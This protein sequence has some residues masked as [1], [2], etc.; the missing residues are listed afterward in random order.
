MT[1]M[2]ARSPSRR[3]LAAGA[4]A[5]LSFAAAGPAR[6]DVA[7]QIIGLSNDE[8]GS[9]RASLELAQY[10]TR[11]DVT[12]AQL[13]RLATR[14][15]GEIRRA[16]EPYG[17]YETKVTSE[18]SGDAPQSRVVFRV[19]R[20]E[21]T[22]VRRADVRIEG[23]ATEVPVIRAALD[24][25]EPRVGEGLDHHLYE[26]NKSE[27]GTLLSAWGFFDAELERHRVEVTRATRS[28]EIDLAWRGGQRYRI[29]DV[30]FDE[31]QL[32]ESFLR[33]YIPWQDG[34]DYSVEQLLALQQRLV[35]ADYFSTV[36]VQPDLDAR[37]GGVVPVSVLLVPARRSIYTA[38]A[39]VSTDVGPGARLGFE[40][41][42]LNDDGHKF[43]AGLEHSSRLQSATLFYRVPRP[44]RRN[45]MYGLAAG[46]RDEITAADTRSRL[47]RISANET[48]DN[49]G[50]YRRVLGLQYVNGDFTVAD[51][52]RNSSLLFAEGT[53]QRKRADDLLFPTRGVSVLYTARAAAQGLLTD[54]SLLQ[55]R[56]DLKWVR[57]AGADS[58]LILRA[59]AGALQTGNFNA[60][61]PELRFFAGG[62]RSVRGFDFQAIGERNETGGVVGG[63]YLSVASA[64]YEHYFWNSVGLA[65]FVDS[66][67]AFNR[68]PEFNVGA[69]LGLRWRSPIGI[70]RLDFAL[71]VRT[72][73]DDG[74]L[75]FHIVIG[76]DL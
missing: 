58:R 4:L 14:G 72:D 29:G 25:F 24:A 5:L 3:R 42:W 33:R 56:A 43:G 16:M 49:W 23:P 65:A 63:R 51:E 19:V 15:E 34:T 73:L 18:I 11:D 75:R 59:S 39:F 36:S 17:Y 22:L 48:L 67:D 12:P 54:T 70:L 55:V 8:A 35:D 1:R 26:I 41:R 64:E 61:P 37:E 45:R 69:G 13:R 6:A 46:Y 50:G 9:A 66:G 38:N 30:R 52:Q 62:D 2:L 32:P 57:P 44:G 71:P 40:R 10:A 74:G 21:R 60:L 53:L 20:G 28:A 27:I 68:R 31:A 76:P 47:S 7:I